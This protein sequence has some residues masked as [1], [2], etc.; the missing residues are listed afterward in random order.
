[1]QK[2]DSTLQ[3]HAMMQ[4]ALQEAQ[5]AF[6][7]GEVPVGA[8]LAVEGK[9]LARARNRVEELRDASA[10]AELLC[11]REG[12]QKLRDWRLLEATLYTT[13]EPCLMCAG[14]L[15]LFR[16]KRVVWGAPDLR[17]GANG[18]LTDVFTLPHPTHS[19]IIEGGLYE[20]E[21][22]ALLRA[23]FKQQRKKVLS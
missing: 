1:M 21:S 3:D 16:I 7:R 18:S 23:F 17:H 12:A 4:E 8:I 20:E 14:A 11:L 5:L 9:I 6:E 22:A 10:H 15:F 13:L 2:K 19:L